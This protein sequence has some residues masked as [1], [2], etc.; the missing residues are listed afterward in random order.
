MSLFGN[1]SVGNWGSQNK[2]KLN[3][4]PEELSIFERNFV[5]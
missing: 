3:T 5:E 2:M 4:N 1:I